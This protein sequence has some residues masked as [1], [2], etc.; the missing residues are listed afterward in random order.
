MAE[1][2]SQ[3]E[4]SQILITEHSE[5]KKN[6]RFCPMLPEIYTSNSPTNENQFIDSPTTVHG[7]SSLDMELNEI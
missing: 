5:D 7:D 3:T 6:H 1:L 2:T 4:E